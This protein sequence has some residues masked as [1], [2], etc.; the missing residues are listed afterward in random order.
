MNRRT[1]AHSPAE[2]AVDRPAEG[3]AAVGHAVRRR[4][5]D[6]GAGDRPGALA[7]VLFDRDGTLVEDVPY[8]GDPEL[9]R[10]VP[11][12]RQ[13]L[14]LL[15]AAGIATGVVSNQSGVGRG[16]LTDADVRRVNDRADALLGGLGT[17]V[18][19]PHLPDDG[20]ACRK[21]EPGLVIEAARRL[22]VAP[23]DCVVIGDIAADV[24]AAHAAGARGV[25]V[26]NA[27]TLPD[28]V[29][30]AP[31]TAPDLLTAVTRLLAEPRGGG[32]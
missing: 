2:R 19:C 14:D 16:L 21:P 17:W 27:A 5:R 24:R 10:P 18:Y 32:A 26:P 22:G 28:E 7:A 4:T 25:L 9:V 8:N 1:M 6:G 15:R 31:R 3:S 29:R 20:C 13:A 23:A 12:A 11:G 30:T